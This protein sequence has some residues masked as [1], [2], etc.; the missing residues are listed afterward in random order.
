MNDEGT[1]A[2]RARD[3]A[4]ALWQDAEEQRQQHERKRRAILTS[5]ARLF[6]ERGF[7]ETTLDEIAAELQVTK[8]T[9]YHYIRSK[10]DILFQIAHLAM[11]EMNTALAAHDDGTL[12]ANLRLEHF[13]QVYGE[14]LL[15][16]FGVCMA[17]VSDR[18][19]PLRLRQELRAIKKALE[20]RARV[21]IEVGRLDGSLHVEDARMLAFAIFGALN[22]IPQWF[23]PQGTLSAS[24]VASAMASIFRR[25]SE[26]SADG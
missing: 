12:P 10:D 5:A 3:R 11:E 4:P 9:I 15:T 8:P 18:A 14:F 24:S 21:I 22:S 23:S 17:L 25:A 19:L 16:D 1:K 2:P 26:A 7:H 13:I 20:H 6:A